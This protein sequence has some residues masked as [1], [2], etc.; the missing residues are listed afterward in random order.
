VVRGVLRASPKGYL[1]W[2]IGEELDIWDETHVAQKRGGPVWWDGYVRT[3]LLARDIMPFLPVSVLAFDANSFNGPW[4]PMP[5]IADVYGLE[6]YL[7]PN[8]DEDAE[9]RTSRMNQIR[10]WMWVAA[11]GARARSRWSRMEYEAPSQKTLGTTLQVW[12][13]RTWNGSGRAPSTTEHRF[14]AYDAL[15]LGS[16]FLAYYNL[17][18]D[19]WHHKFNPLQWEGWRGVIEEVAALSPALTG[20]NV[21]G[22]FKT[23]LGTVDMGAREY[24]GHLYVIAANHTAWEGP[25]AVQCPV[26]PAA[27]TEWA[28]V[29]EN[30]AVPAKDGVIRDRIG[31]FGVHIYTD[32]TGMKSTRLATILKDPRFGGTP[33][34]SRV[35]GNLACEKN[36]ATVA[37][38]YHIWNFHHEVFA[39]DGDP[40]TAYITAE[41]MKDPIVKGPYTLTVTPKSPSEVASIVLRSWRP[42]HWP[43]PV[44][45]VRDYL[46]E[47]DV[48]GKWETVAN[49]KGNQEEVVEHRFP[50]RVARAIRLTIYGGL[51]VNEIEAYGPS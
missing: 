5:R 1:A 42:K 6:P 27:A 41:W 35:G 3:Y 40:E 38:N 13:G 20:S 24:D 29:S 44:E 39:I 16:T 51:F 33:T 26:S 32:N 46:L 45:G 30:R 14:M 15:L 31:P 43:D 23:L 9:Q 37:A 25:M 7:Y 10:T 18:C 17:H 34:C 47:V 22:R 2:D 50:P 8:Y 49:A 12:D 48:G 36:G 11:E 19:Y 4:A 28:V 21:T